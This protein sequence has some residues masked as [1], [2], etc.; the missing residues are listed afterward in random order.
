[1][2][3]GTSY[4]YRSTVNLTN[5][6]HHSGVYIGWYIVTHPQYS[7]TLKTPSVLIFRGKCVHASYFDSLASVLS[8]AGHFRPSTHS[9]PIP[10]VKSAI[11][12]GSMRWAGLH[13]WLHSPQRTQKN[14]PTPSGSICKLLPNSSL[15]HF[16]RPL[17]WILPK[18]EL[19]LA[20]VFK[21]VSAVSRGW[22]WVGLGV[23]IKGGEWEER[24]L[25]LSWSEL[26]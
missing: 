11:Q 25:F 1:M 12:K 22:S 16:A 4:N 10:N 2:I 26:P 19:P 3:V 20:T 5:S 13:T 23:T 15:L 18:G 8:P 14:T 17:F 7:I 21:I 24:D 6:I 9:F